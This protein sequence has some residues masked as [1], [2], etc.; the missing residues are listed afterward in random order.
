M[1]FIHVHVLL[2]LF[3]GDEVSRKGALTGGYH[4]SRRSKLENQRMIQELSSKIE[5]LE[6]EKLTITRQSQDVSLYSYTNYM[7]VLWGE[8]E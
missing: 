3:I 6:G 7:Y 5:Q 4:D 8:S 2:V 1:L